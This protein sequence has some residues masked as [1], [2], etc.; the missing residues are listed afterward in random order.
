MD[1]KAL[2]RIQR[3]A[4]KNTDNPN[5]TKIYLHE[6]QIFFGPGMYMKYIILLGILGKRDVRLVACNKCSRGVL[7]R[8]EILF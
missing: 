7:A 5:K 4:T 2:V 6:W 1:G 3:K 8:G